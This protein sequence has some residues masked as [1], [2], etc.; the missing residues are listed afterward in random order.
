MGNHKNYGRI[1]LKLLTPLIIFSALIQFLP[2]P[3]I[4]VDMK[5]AK[6]RV[7]GIS[8]P[9]AG[10]VTIERD[11]NREILYRCERVKENESIRVG[12]GGWVELRFLN[13]GDRIRMESHSGIAIEKMVRGD[14]EKAVNALLILNHGSL[15]ARLDKGFDSTFTV[16]TGNAEVTVEKGDC[17]I[18]YDDS[19][20]RSL[21]VVKALYDGGSVLVNTTD[22]SSKDAVGVP[23]GKKIEIIGEVE[24]FEVKDAGIELAL[25]GK[26]MKFVDEEG[27]GAVKTTP[28]KLGIRGEKPS[29]D[30]KGEA[31]SFTRK[32]VDN[33]NAESV[34]GIRGMVSGSYSGNIGGYGSRTA[35]I[36]GLKEH[37]DT[38][39]RSRL[40]YSVGNVGKTDEAGG[41]I[42]IDARIGGNSVKFWITKEGGSYYLTHAEGGWFYE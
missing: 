17:I 25:F 34:S 4:A 22:K 18:R 5:P 29:I 12:K 35:L 27:Y 14:K 11:G 24:G 36:N 42:I 26:T 23:E 41:G 38:G 32:F 31:E 3:V 30:V 33:L 37:F 8:R 21:I 2:D 15:R 28:K 16:R 39:K 6:S 13:K 7:K 19:S 9:E 10:E 40:T 20:R 1:I